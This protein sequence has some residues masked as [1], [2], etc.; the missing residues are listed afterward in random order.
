MSNTKRISVSL[1]GFGLLFVST[2][3]AADDLRI[4]GPF[5]QENLSIYLVH[6][7]IKAVK[8]KLLPLQDAMTQ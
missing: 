2:A 1:L 8:S 6:G 5:T 3:A 4:S 7:S